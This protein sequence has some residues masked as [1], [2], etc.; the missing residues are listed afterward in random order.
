MA[1]NNNSLPHCRQ[2]MIGFVFE[3]QGQFNCKFKQSNMSQSSAEIPLEPENLASNGENIAPES[4]VVSSNESE[5]NASSETNAES[6]IATQEAE[7]VELKDKYL[8][9]Y[10]EFDNFRKRVLKEKSELKIQATADVIVKLL[11]VV[12]DFHR[13]QNAIEKTEDTA[14]IK[15]GMVLVFNKLNKV[16]EQLGLKIMPTI[17]QSFDP[18]FHESIASV[19]TEDESL[20]GKIMD[21]VQRGYF[22]HD[23]PIR[24]AKVV[25]GA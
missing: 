14:V 22:L 16:L 13:T 15:E 3:L 6:K 8:R 20:K 5:L 25:I 19:P 2:Y 11:E 7:I 23:K 9:L 21:E 1:A 4:T 12:D 18:D 24:F 17:G 10:S